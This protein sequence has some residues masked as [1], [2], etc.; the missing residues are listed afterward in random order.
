M[1]SDPTSLD[2]L[3]DIVP[4]PAVPW[5]PPAPAWYWVLGL[6]GIAVVV[7]LLR[8]FMHWQRNRYRREA[9]AEFAKHEVKLH[10]ASQR[11]GA[12]IALAELLKQTAV[13]AFPREDVAS[14]TGTSW[15]SFLDRTVSKKAFVEGNGSLLETAAYDPRS[16]SKVDE[17][18][19]REL[20]RQV[21]DWL[22]HHQVDIYQGGAA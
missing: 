4:P 9:L 11:G 3:H 13:T 14:L 8:V 12:L 20:A 18:K 15:D 19:A 7:F 5:W 16:I 17:T 1:Q 10:D 2:R 6:L 21:R 22:A